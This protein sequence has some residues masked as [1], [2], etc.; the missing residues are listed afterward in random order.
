MHRDSFAFHVEI[1]LANTGWQM[2]VVWIAGMIVKTFEDAGKLST[3]LR[4]TV[5]NE[6]A[7]RMKLRAGQSRSGQVRSGHADACCQSTGVVLLSLLEPKNIG[8]ALLTVGR[9][10]AWVWGVG[11]VVLRFLKT[12]CWIVG[13]DGEWQDA[14]DKCVTGSLVVHGVQQH[15]VLQ[16]VKLSRRHK[17]VM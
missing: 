9:P 10:A 6:T 1:N 8:S 11:C 4:T 3:Y 13:I 15:E 5:V 12:G 17:Q 7:F 14:G 16:M 2:A